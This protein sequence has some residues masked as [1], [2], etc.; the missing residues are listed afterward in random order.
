MGNI[1]AKCQCMIVV[2]VIARLVTVNKTNDTVSKRFITGSKSIYI[3]GDYNYRDVE[4]DEII[5][6][7][8]KLDRGKRMKMRYNRKIQSA[9][10]KHIMRNDTTRL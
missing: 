8:S 2:S 7:C 1:S 9:C 5:R 6:K 3:Y 10:F 4:G